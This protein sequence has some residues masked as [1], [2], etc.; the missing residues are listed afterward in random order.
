[1]DRPVEIRNS[2][3]EWAVRFLCILVFVGLAGAVS[4]AI[5]A[6]KTNDAMEDDGFAAAMA[7][8]RASLPSSEEVRALAR[9]GKIRFHDCVADTLFTDRAKPMVVFANR[10][11]VQVNLELCEKK[12][13]DLQPNH[14]FMVLLA[15]SESI[16][17]PLLGEGE[18]FRYTFNTC[19][20]PYCTPPDSDC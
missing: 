5:A 18:S 4:H 9:G 11:G 15:N 1:M 19:G 13:N 17:R 8:H 3:T 7:K 10:C 12:S 14:Y 16:Y 20:A 6:E 2:R